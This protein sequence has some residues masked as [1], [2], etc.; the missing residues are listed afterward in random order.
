MLNFKEIFIKTLGEPISTSALDL[1][2]NFVIE[3]TNNIND[4]ER[5]EIHHLLPSSCF[6]E[7]IKND[8]NL[9]P[10]SYKNHV[11]AHIHLTSAYKIKKFLRP[12][13]FMINREEK[14][15]IEYTK[16]WSTACN[17]VTKLKTP[18]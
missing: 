9:F 17:E 7:Y 3:S 5:I 11:L 2:I 16:K 13:N 4:N 1:Y 6:E 18:S 10:L 12:L 15:S 8:D 14:N